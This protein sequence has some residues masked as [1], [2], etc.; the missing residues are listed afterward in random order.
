[1]YNPDCH[2]EGGEDDALD[3]VNDNEMSAS[4]GSRVASASQTNVHSL[5]F[6]LKVNIAK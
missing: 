6:L 4:K 1:M 2:R 3:G 5:D